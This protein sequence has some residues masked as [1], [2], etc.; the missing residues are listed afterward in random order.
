MK[1]YISAIFLCFIISGLQAQDDAIVKFFSKYMEDDNFSRVYISPKMMQMAGGFL[2]SADSKDEDSQKMGELISRVK[3]IRILSADKVSGN[4]LY[5][6]AMSTL[7][8]NLYEDLMDVADK[9]SNIKFMVREEKGK[10]KELI[11]ISG[12]KDSF[13]L[14]SMLGD[15]SYQDLN[16][17]ADKTNIPGMDKYK[18]GK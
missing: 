11:M 3:G 13:T 10:V 14:L 1:K 9:G 5:K 17:L 16:I 15:F 2:K 7:N 12:S 18:G 4:N 8:K 6:E